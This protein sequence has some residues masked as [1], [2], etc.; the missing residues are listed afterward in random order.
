MGKGLQGFCLIFLLLACTTLNAQTHTVTYVYTDPQGT[1]LAEADASGNI[2]ATFDYRPYGNLV[3]GA[4]P[5]GPGYAGHVNDP[6]TGL[7]YMQARYYDPAVGRFVSIDPHPVSTG[8]LF[9]INRFVYANNAP[10]R[11]VDERGDKPGDKFKTPEMAAYD[12]LQWINGKSI[13]TNHEYQGWITIVDGQFVATEPVQMKENG[14]VT[15]P[16]GVPVVGDY[17]THGNYATLNPDGTFTAT[18]DPSKDNLNSDQFSSDDIKRYDTLGGVNGVYRG[19]LATPGQKFLVYDA[20]TR[21][22]FNLVQVVQQ[23]QQQQ[24]P[25]VPP[26]QPPQPPPQEPKPPQQQ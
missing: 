25:P 4:S 20:K 17:H 14:G 21:K 13:A 18:G 7:V 19:Y 24:T 8:A 10:T 6:D 2:T 22:I 3:L 11:Y 16:P 9:F 23:Q 26:P 12:T 15:A 5:S 1:T